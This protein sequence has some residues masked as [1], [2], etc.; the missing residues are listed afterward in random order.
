[1]LYLFYR[2]SSAAQSTSYKAAPLDRSAR[3]EMQVDRTLKPR[4]AGALA[5]ATNLA[6]LAASFWLLAHTL[7]GFPRPSVSLT[8][9]LVGLPWVAVGMVWCFPG[10]FFFFPV[11]G[12]RRL[13]L[14]GV[15]FLAS[16][17]PFGTY[18]YAAPVRKLPVLGLACA[19]GAILFAALLV[20]E[21]RA[22]GNTVLLLIAFPLSFGYGYAA[23]VQLNCVLDHSAA[24]VYKTVVTD[25]SLRR[26]SLD[27]QPWGPEP[28]AKSIM[29]PYHT[30]VPQRIFDAVQKG[31]PICVAQKDGA[32]GIRWYTAQVCPW[33][34]QP[35]VLGVGGSLAR[36]H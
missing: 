34:G 4:K 10:R 6:L 25:K 31:G 27:I 7:L 20:S 24:M 28:E 12:D 18:C 36:R 3:G 17:A 33:N 1:V 2:R 29:T 26:P 11:P 32:L 8:V 13:T 5:L 23:V 19:V 9:V 14:F 30:L 22:K 35:V 16:M 15:L 21:V